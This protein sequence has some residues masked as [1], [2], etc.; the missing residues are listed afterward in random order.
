VSAGFV[1]LVVPTRDG[2]AACVAPPSPSPFD[3][4]LLGRPAEAP[5]AGSPCL[6]EAESYEAGRRAGL[7]EA[8]LSREAAA[9]ATLDAL[10]RAARDVSEQAA[11]QAEAV[12]EELAR[13]LL[14]M[15]DAALPGLARR[16]AEP[17]VAAFVARLAPAVAEAARPVVRVA[18]SLAPLLA[19]RLPWPVEPDLSLAEGDARVVWQ[20]GEAAFRLDDR[21]AALRDALA[22]LGLTKDTPA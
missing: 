21:R 9:A 4:V 18:P 19:G 22:L 3:T 15:A 12:L 20:G 2:L 17:L 5:G 16:E 8:T 6:P 14:A 7:A 10:A 11:R 13:T 1:P